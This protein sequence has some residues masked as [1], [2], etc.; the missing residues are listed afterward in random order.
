[1]NAGAAG[2][3]LLPVLRLTGQL[4]LAYGVLLGLALGS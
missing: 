2:R 1:V 3:D 4:E